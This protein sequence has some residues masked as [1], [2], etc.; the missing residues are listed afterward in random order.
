MSSNEVLRLHIDE[1]QSSLVADL[2]NRVG[3]EEGA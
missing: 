2:G 3:D 1:E